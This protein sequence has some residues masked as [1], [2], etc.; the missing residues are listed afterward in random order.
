MAYSI[1]ASIELSVPSTICSTIGSTSRRGSSGAVGHGHCLRCTF[2][3]RCP[4]GFAGGAH[5]QDAVRIDLSFWPGKTTVVEPNSSTTAG[6]SS[7]CPPAARRAR[8]S[9]CRGT[10]RRNRPAGCRA[11]AARRIARVREAGP[12]DQPE[13]RDAEIDQL[14]LLLAGIIV[15]EGLQ[16]RGV[17][18]VD[19]AGNELRVDRARRRRY[20]HFHRLPG[21]AHVGFAHQRDLR[22]RDAVARQRRDGVLFQRP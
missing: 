15:A 7:E 14:D 21:V 12:L 6:P 19:Q 10:R 22:W 18:G 16:M 11:L 1:S 8:R 2:I 5:D 20:A 4:R 13:S 3:M 17:E 9:A